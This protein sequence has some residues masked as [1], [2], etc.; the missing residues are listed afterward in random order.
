MVGV[1]I[2]LTDTKIIV[3]PILIVET[4]ARVVIDKI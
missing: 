1:F 4:D 3:I 2:M